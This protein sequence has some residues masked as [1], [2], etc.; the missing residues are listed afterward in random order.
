MLANQDSRGR[1]RPGWNNNLR[2]STPPVLVNKPI[3]TI[4][5]RLTRPRGSRELHDNSITHTFTWTTLVDFP[6]ECLCNTYLVGIWIY[7]LSNEKCSVKSICMH[8]SLYKTQFFMEPVLFYTSGCTYWERTIWTSDINKSTNT[9]VSFRAHNY[10]GSVASLSFYRPRFDAYTHLETKLFHR[11]GSLP[12]WKKSD[13]LR[14]SSY[15]SSGENQSIDE[16]E[17][18]V[19]MQTELRLYGRTDPS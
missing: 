15:S 7:P 9:P 6:F 11:A 18:A 14:R 16:K 1:T 10:S 12:D 3:A 17:N 13:Q 5:Y 4:V 2:S 8:L 19:L